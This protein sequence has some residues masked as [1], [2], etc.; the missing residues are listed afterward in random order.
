MSISPFDL[1]NLVYVSL[2]GKVFRSAL[3]T[4]GVFMGVVAISAPLQVY[5]I[6]RAILLS[7]CRAHDTNQLTF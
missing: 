1:L 4:L 7:T 3:S 6:G 2:R 5:Y